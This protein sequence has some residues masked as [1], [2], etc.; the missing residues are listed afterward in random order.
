M[1]LCCL[2]HT[3]RHT[4]PGQAHASDR[5]RNQEDAPFKIAIESRHGLFDERVHAK[6]V[7]A[8]ALVPLLFVHGRKV[9][10]VGEF[11]P[12]CIPDDDVQT[13]KCSDCL[14]DASCAVGEVAA[15]TFNHGGLDLV[16]LLELLCQCLSGAFAVGVVD[17]YVAAFRGE[18]ASDLCS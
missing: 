11:G 3:V 17:R 16:L 2:S 18:L 13:V 7:D 5:A 15:V 12:A 14:L 9:S 1:Q 8:P 4:A 6:D 10:K